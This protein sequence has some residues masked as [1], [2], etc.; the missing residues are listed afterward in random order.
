MN[1]DLSGEGATVGALKRSLD[2]QVGV[3]MRDVVLNGFDLWYTIRQASAQVTGGGDPGTDRG[4]TRITTLS[5]TADARDGL[6]TSDDLSAR[7]PYLDLTG[8]GTVDL[9]SSMV[10]YDLQV[11]VIRNPELEGDPLAE[12]L[13]DVPVPVTFRGPYDDFEQMSI[14]PDIDAVLAAKARQRIDEEVED[15]EDRARS[16]LC[17]LLGCDD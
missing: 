13:Y 4:E 1:I 16:R 3:S 11:L 15:L 7:L 6:F 10:D 2:G 5:M 9:G 8:A 14:Q 12:A 17:S